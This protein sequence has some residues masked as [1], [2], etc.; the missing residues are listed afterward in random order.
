MND[1]FYESTRA[2]YH[3]H[4]SLQG[5]AAPQESKNTGPPAEIFEALTPPNGD[6]FSGFLTD[7]ETKGVPATSENGCSPF[8]HTTR[9][10]KS[11][12]IL[13]TLTVLPPRHQQ[14]CSIASWQPSCL[15]SGSMLRC[16]RINFGNELSLS[17]P[18][19]PY[20]PPPILSPMRSGT[21]L[22]YQ[23]IGD[24]KKSGMYIFVLLGS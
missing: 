14:K 24:Q 3:Q 9:R 4:K 13:P 19:K 15:Q 23:L 11:T 5:P 17:F 20:T 6:D 7:R 18:F 22:F 21:G 16:P 8:A 10:T 2:S 1:S 12:S